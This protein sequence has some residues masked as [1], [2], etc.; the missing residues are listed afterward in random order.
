[1]RH[2]RYRRNQERPDLDTQR[3]VSELQRVQYIVDDELGRAIKIALMQPSR[4][5][6]FTFAET[7]DAALR[8]LGIAS[9]YLEE[10]RQQIGAMFWGLE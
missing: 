3:L 4:R 1:V 7:L 2:T 6:D 10:Q 8:R 9:R 5:A